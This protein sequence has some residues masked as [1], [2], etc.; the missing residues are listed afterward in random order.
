MIVKI[1]WFHPVF[2]ETSQAIQEALLLIG[3]DSEAI[4]VDEKYSCDTDDL[5]IM[6]DIHHTPRFPKNYI[7]IQNEQSGSNWINEQL[8]DLMS[9]ALGVWEFNPKHNEKWKQ[10]GYNSFHVPMRT[11]VGPYLEGLPEFVK[12]IDVLFYGT[13]GDRRVQ[14][15]RRLRKHFPKKKIVFRYFDLF[16]K[17]REDFISRAKIV[18]NIRYWPE[19]I[20]QAHR[21]EYLLARGKCVVSETSGDDTLDSDYVGGIRFCDYDD[22]VPVIRN[23]LDNPEEIELLGQRGRRTGQIHQ[24]DMR[25]MKKA[26]K[27]CL[28]MLD[29]K[30]HQTKFGVLK[31]RRTG[32][33][34]KTRPAE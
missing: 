18:L 26:L 24:F 12:D 9:R 15:E 11:P 22:F 32:A 31:N 30:I 29:V 10:L 27:G 8:F 7:L 4:C 13:K 20:L 19:G 14:V 6:V 33:T 16:G 25:P 1:V 23:L 34:E 3:I 28:K 2:D 21:I 17:E 5:Y